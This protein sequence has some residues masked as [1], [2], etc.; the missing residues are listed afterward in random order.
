M[1][2]FDKYF[3]YTEANTLVP[4]IR[5]IFLRIQELIGKVNFSQQTVS[6]NPETLPIPRT[7]GK[8]KNPE[9][10]K[11]DHL[12]E[13]NELLSE[14]TDQGVI[15]QDVTRGLIDFPAYIQ[16]E[17]VFLCYEMADGEEIRFYHDMDS[18]YGSRK[19]IE[20]SDK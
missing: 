10:Q 5:W 18:G 7:N 3:T 8:H 19:L 12:K 11:R 2:Y 4:R 1:P 16:G 9:R 20:D 17:E 13:I 6:I 15:I 14:I